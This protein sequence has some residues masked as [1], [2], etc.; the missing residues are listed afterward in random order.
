VIRTTWLCLLAPSVAIVVFA[1]VGD[2]PEPEKA[3]PAEAGAEASVEAG[4]A[5]G[6]DASADGPCN[7]GAGWLEPVPL[8][9]VNSPVNDQRPTLSADELTIYFSSRRGSAGADAGA[10]RIF[11]AT[12]PD[13]RTD[14]FGEPV[15]L[16]PV[17]N[18]P[19]V[20]TVGASLSNDRRRLYF[21]AGGAG[22]P[23]ILYEA[24]H[25]QV[26]DTSWAAATL[27]ALGD[28]DGGVIDF[29]PFI[30]TDGTLYFARNGT[31][32]NYDVHRADP[33]GANGFKTPSRIAEL[34]SAQDDSDPTLSPDNLTIY[35][36]SSRPGSLDIDIWS[37][38]R[39][40][41]TSGF[42][43]PT[44]VAELSSPTRDAPGWVSPDGCR[45]YLASDRPGGR[46]LLDIF[47]A[48]KPK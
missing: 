12:R 41:T 7:L 6:G 45:M 8:N 46:G 35:F 15:A 47:V 2:N 13:N 1:C 21:S 10:S 34:A 22:A 44:R 37:A 42:P 36:S 26:A 3:E 11:V 9:S 48:S 28:P 23:H 18:Q 32:P 16:S 19:D 14:S 33:D 40:T 4:E 30:A 31:P 27:K 17:V 39:T 38:T 20:D 25:A 43:P 29:S 5:G 24:T